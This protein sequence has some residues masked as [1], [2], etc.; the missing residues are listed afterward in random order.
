MVVATGF[1]LPYIEWSS[2]VA[3]PRESPVHIIFQPIAKAAILN[4][5]RVPVYLTVARNKVLFQ[6]SGS[7]IPGLLNIVEEG[8]LTAPAEGLGMTNLLTAEEQILFL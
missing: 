1:T 7:D 5:L 2:P 3:L 6:G 8:C 4:M